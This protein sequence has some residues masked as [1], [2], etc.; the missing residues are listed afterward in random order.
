MV[1]LAAGSPLDTDTLIFLDVFIVDPINLII[2]NFI[3]AV[4]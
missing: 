1:K 3:A 4:I 2:E